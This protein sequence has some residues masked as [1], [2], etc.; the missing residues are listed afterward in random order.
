MTAGN[1]HN[2]DFPVAVATCLQSREVGLQNEKE[3]RKKAPET[4]WRKGM[5]NVGKGTIIAFFV[6]FRTSH[7]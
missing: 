3:K 2:F 6:V 4:G 5:N 7:L 1:S